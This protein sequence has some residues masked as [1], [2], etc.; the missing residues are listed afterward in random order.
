MGNSAPACPLQFDLH[1][2]R[3]QPSQQLL[4]QSDKCARSNCGSEPAKR[5]PKPERLG[6]ASVKGQLAL[7]SVPRESHGKQPTSTL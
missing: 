5:T 2:W 6:K 7:L 3:P 4:S 1:I